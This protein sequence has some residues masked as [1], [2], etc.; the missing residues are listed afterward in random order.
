MNAVDR[1]YYEIIQEGQAC[2]LYFDLEYSKALNPQLD[3]ARMMDT[4]KRFI[5][6]YLKTVHR[7]IVG[8]NDIVDLESSS[9]SKFSRHLIV[10]IKNAVFKNND[11]MGM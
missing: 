2:H 6:Q 4:F 10:R 3:S 11:E 5:C 7:V 8:L 9:E 1:H